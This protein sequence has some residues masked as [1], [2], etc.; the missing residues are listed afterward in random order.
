MVRSVFATVLTA[1]LF[2]GPVLA[3]TTDMVTYADT[4]RKKSSAHSAV[5][6][7][8]R[9]AVSSKHAAGAKHSV[10][11]KRTA[12]AKHAAPKAKHHK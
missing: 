10:A 5:R 3:Q 7:V 8:T 6:P 9:G 11:A 12:S 1:V 2:A 4:M